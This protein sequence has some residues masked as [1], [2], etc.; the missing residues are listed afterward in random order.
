MNPDVLSTVRQA[1]RYVVAYER[2]LLDAMIRVDKAVG[3][4]CGYQFQKRS[5]TLTSAPKSR[6]NADD[7]A[8]DNHTLFATQFL[9]ARGE[10][11]NVAG[12][13]WLLIDHVADTA[14]EERLERGEPDPLM[15]KAATESETVLRVWWLKLHKPVPA[16]L[17]SKAWS[18]LAKA[19]FGADPRPKRAGED[20][21]DRTHDGVT[22]GGFA[23]AVQELNAPEA[24]ERV[25]VQPVLTRLN[26]L[27]ARPLGG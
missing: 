9:W 17:W 22:V 13:S 4:E 11:E 20:V 23:L 19:H 26:A 24:L 15:L 27:E 25:L 3:N 7:W 2:R 16:S 8:W 6:L 21:P 5:P 1:Y 18:D 14:F 10:F 12:S